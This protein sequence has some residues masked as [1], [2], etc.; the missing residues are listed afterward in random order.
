MK[1][2]NK[3]IL[4]IS[5]MATGLLLAMGSKAVESSPHTSFTV[6]PPGDT[7][8]GLIGYYYNDRNN[9]LHFTTLVFSRL[10]SIFWYNWGGNSPDPRITNDTFSVRWRGMFRVPVSG[11]YTFNSNADDGFKFIIKDYA[12]REA[13]PGTVVM[14]NKGNCCS[15]F[16]GQATLEAGKLYPIEI[17]FF[18]G[19]GG[20]NIMYFKWTGPNI[21]QQQVP[22][23]Y[24][25]ALLP[26]VAARPKITPDR[27]LF[28]GSVAVTMST[29]TDGG[30][31]HYTLDGTTPTVNSPVYNPQD[32]LHI[33]STT[34]VKASTYIDGMYVSEVSS[35]L[36]SV[37]PPVIPDP[38][39]VPSAGI[40]NDPVKMAIVVGEPGSTI[41]YTTDGSTPT[42]A[43]LVYTDSIH[44][45][46]TM[47]IKAFAVKEGRTASQVTAGTYTILPEGT[48]QP[49]FSIAEGTYASAQQ[50][51]ISCATP[52]AVIHYALNDNVLNSSSPV[53]TAP[54]DIS[55]IA[56]LKAYASAD[57]LSDSRVAIASY[58]IG[59]DEAAA[60]APQ[61][62]F[63]GGTYNGVRQVGLFTDT[64][65]ATIYYTT[66]GSMPDENSSIYY[67]LIQVTDSVTINAIAVKAG[68][69]ASAVSSATYVI[70]GE[71][72][73]TS[74]ID[75]HLPPALLSITPNPAGN[76]ARISW[77]GIVI[78]R[79]GYRVVV[80][81]SRGAVVATTL[82]NGGYTYCVINTSTLADGVYFVKVLSGNSVAKGK[83]IIAR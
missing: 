9:G 78:T 79:D 81:D 71:A 48:K 64:K 20:A 72:R 45:D 42:T 21:P 34:T 47:R 50:V 29:T 61:F 54:V 16:S 80:T 38:V 62:S 26:Q 32:T 56:T 19:G 1:Q 40:Y 18:E 51:A 77:T 68:M 8:R 75:T 36:L 59:N 41:Y 30:V 70:I 49:V 74:L 46:S 67:N 52:G 4:I 43:S 15:D 55:T 37:M 3:L 33:T 7:A 24:F 44:I 57:G 35:A 2:L 31:I 12:N 76:Q 5:C 60:S 58:I 17:E 73:D 10:D 39:F 13:D 28:E 83:L 63:P 23:S 6:A 25:Y 69:K 82:V 22:S 27:G 65:G 66:D 14:D 11:T 53:Y